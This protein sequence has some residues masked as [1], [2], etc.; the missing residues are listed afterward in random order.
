[1]RLGVEVPFWL[2]GGG[3]WRGRSSSAGVSV[4]Q[5]Y[6]YPLLWLFLVHLWMAGARCSSVRTRCTSELSRSVLLPLLLGLQLPCR[7]IASPRV[8]VPRQGRCLSSI[9]LPWYGVG[10]LFW[11]LWAMAPVHTLVLGGLH[12]LTDR[13]PSC[14][15][16]GAGVPFEDGGGCHR[17]G[18]RPWSRRECLLLSAS[19]RQGPADASVRWSAHV[20]GLHRLQAA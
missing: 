1:M 9:C 14:Q 10:T 17:V 12:L 7:A 6:S 3:W 16:E 5:G 20:G 11:L 19:C 18:Q 2:S 13:R 8:Q 4:W 15:G